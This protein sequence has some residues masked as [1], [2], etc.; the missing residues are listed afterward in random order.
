MWRRLIIYNHQTQEI[1]EEI[2]LSIAKKFSQI[3]GFT[4]DIAQMSYKNS[5]V[6]V[7]FKGWGNYGES[8]YL[9]LTMYD[10]KSPIKA[11]KLGTLNNQTFRIGRFEVKPTGRRYGTIS[12]TKFITAMKDAGFESSVLYAQNEKSFVFWERLGFRQDKHSKNPYNMRLNLK[13]AK[14]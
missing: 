5:K 10:F 2:F 4:I 3:M 6:Y 13:E 8:F 1:N 9:S 14:T 12:M 7:T 11:N